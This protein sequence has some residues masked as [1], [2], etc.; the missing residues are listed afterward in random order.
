MVSALD[1]AVGIVVSALRSS[2]LYNNSVIVFTSD[3]GGSTKG[4][5]SNWPLKGH[6]STLWEGGVRVPGFVHSPLLSSPGV[7]RGLFHAVDWFATIAGLAG[8][9][10]PPEVDGVDQWAALAGREAPARDS[11]VYNI[12][13][14]QDALKA[15]VREG[16]YKLV[17]GETRG[18]VWVK[19]G[20]AEQRLAQKNRKDD[21]TDEEEIREE[22]IRGE[23]ET[24]Q[25]FMI[26]CDALSRKDCRN[27]NKEI[28]A[29]RSYKKVKDFFKDGLELRLYDLHSDPNE[30]EDLSALHPGMVRSLLRRLLQELPRAQASDN[31]PMDMAGDPRRFGSVWSPGWC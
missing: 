13:Y 1:D 23:E 20:I 14:S 21:E 27:R 19:P 8:A 18:N 25:E 4:A 9:A 7:Y 3:N 5:G 29:Y 24:T 2:G 11:F 31:P 30:K 26:N 17:V 12:A 10:V 6:K 22:K 28:N 16:D 15:A